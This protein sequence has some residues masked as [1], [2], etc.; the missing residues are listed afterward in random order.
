MSRNDLD[1]ALVGDV[2]AGGVGRPLVLGDDDVV[3]AVGGEEQRRGRSC[4]TAADH[5]HVGGQHVAAGLMGIAHS[6]SSPVSHV[7]AAPW[8]ERL[9]IS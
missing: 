5:Q 9:S 8:P 7:A 6:A 4:R 1:G 3:D 2:R